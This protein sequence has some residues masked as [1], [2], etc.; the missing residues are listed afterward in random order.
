MQCW[1]QKANYSAEDLPSLDTFASFEKFFDSLELAELDALQQKKEDNKEDCC[2]WG[3]G[4]GHDTS[5]SI[6]IMRMDVKAAK[7]DI[8]WEEVKPKKFLGFIPYNGRVEIWYDDLSIA[9]MKS[10]VRNF[11]EQKHAKKCC[12]ICG[13]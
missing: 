4:I 9:E 2:P 12:S 5:F 13:E 10:H 6:H 8:L 1:L 11:Y 7:F 3:I